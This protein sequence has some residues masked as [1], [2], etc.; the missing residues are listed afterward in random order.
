MQ[1][2]ETE[3]PGTGIKPLKDGHR[4]ARSGESQDAVNQRHN[5]ALTSKDRLVYTK[6]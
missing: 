4:T 3:P 1:E 2:L 5:Q 6:V